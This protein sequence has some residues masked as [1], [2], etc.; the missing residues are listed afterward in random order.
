MIVFGKRWAFIPSFG[1][2]PKVLLHCVDILVFRDFFRNTSSD[3]FEV[4][5]RLHTCRLEE[6][7]WAHLAYPRIS[8]PPHYALATSNLR[9]TSVYI[10]VMLH[11]SFLE[12][13][14]HFL[15]N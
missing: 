13:S 12:F 6:R 5:I 1:A 10:S 9:I 14:Y 4:S 2:D 15:S 7:S 8:L 3:F 11:N